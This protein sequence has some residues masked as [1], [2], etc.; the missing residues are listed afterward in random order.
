[1]RVSLA[2]I[3]AVT[4]GTQVHGTFGPPLPFIRWRA[5]TFL[6]FALLAWSLWKR[7]RLMP[8]LIV[9]HFLLDLQAAAPCLADGSSRHPDRRRQHASVGAGNRPIC[10]P[11]SARA[12]GIPAD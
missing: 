9:V 10:T 1:M 8:Y 6:G 12:A 4:R 7:P 11:M 2:H 3:L 5:S